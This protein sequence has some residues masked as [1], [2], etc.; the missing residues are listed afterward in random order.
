MQSIGERLEEARKRRGIS[1]REASEATKIRGDFLLSFENNQFDVGLPEIYVRGFLR[2][3]G[4]FLKIDSE[5]LAT[6]YN[7]TLIGDARPQRKE[8]REL[9]G[10]M[11]LPERPRTPEPA[12]AAQSTNAAPAQRRQEPA[13]SSFRDRE[14]PGPD[15]MMYA[16]IGGT[17]LAAILAL[18]AIAWL[19]KAL[20]SGSD[21]PANN[22]VEG[23][24]TT[25]SGA[26][27][28]GQD[29]ITLIAL[30]AVRVTVTQTSDGTKL[31]DGGLAKGETKVVPKNGA[32]KITYT[33][34]KNLRLEK[35]GKQYRMPSDSI[36][37]TSMP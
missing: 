16:K 36:G 5:K 24:A 15:L 10:R 9:F 20:F 27:V 12:A 6:D 11:E 32:V 14:V 29:A 17:I 28:P 3:Y 31:F 1:V 13:E 2:N 8:Q 34:G 35:D 37:V 19:V 30:D 25:Q 21:T 26:V 7:A 33:I 18:L 4:S 22:R 23:P